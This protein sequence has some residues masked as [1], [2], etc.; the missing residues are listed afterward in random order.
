MVFGFIKRSAMSQMFYGALFL[1]YFYS[2]VTISSTT[3]FLFS[4]IMVFWWSKV[5]SRAL[6]LHYLYCYKAETLPAKSQKVQWVGEKM[7][8]SFWTP[9]FCTLPA[10]LPLLSTFLATSTGTGPGERRGRSGGSVFF[11][12]G[13]ERGSI[14]LVIVLSTLTFLCLSSEAV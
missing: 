2:F 11:S 5:E 13:K 12:R 9:S 6:A 10:L 8:E 7:N 1:N 14:S 4:I 3:V